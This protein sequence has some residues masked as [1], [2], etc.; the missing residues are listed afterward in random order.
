[1]G[2]GQS[3][4]AGMGATLLTAGKYLFFGGTAFDE[5]RYL[6]EVRLAL[7]AEGLQGVEHSV[8]LGMSLPYV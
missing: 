5:D 2:G 6:A 4:R 8:A 3:P 7:L 1:M